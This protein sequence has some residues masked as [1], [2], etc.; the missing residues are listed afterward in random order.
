MSRMMRNTIAFIIII[1]IFYFQDVTYAS[2]ME[3]Q[4]QHQLFADYS[5]H[6]RP[7]KNFSDVLM[8]G[9]SFSLV[10]L[11]DVDEKNQIVTL[12]A[13]IKHTWHDYQLQ[14]NPGDY[15][16]IEEVV[17]PEEWVWTPDLALANSA[18]DNIMFIS[19]SRS[20]S[21]SHN[22]STRAFSRMVL[23]IPCVMDIRLFPFDTQTCSAY[24]SFWQY[25]HNFVQAES[26]T[27][28]SII[29]GAIENSEWAVLNGTIDV[30]VMYTYFPVEAWSLVV[31]TLTFKRK[32][33]YYVMNIIIPATLMALLTLLVHII[34]CDCGE[35][36]SFSVSLLISMSVFNLMVGNLLPA[37]SESVPLLAQYLLFNTVFVSFSICMAAVVLRLHHRQKGSLDMSFRIRRIFIDILPPFLLIKKYKSPGINKYDTQ[38]LCSRSNV[39]SL[40]SSVNQVD[41][42]D[43]ND[44]VMEVLDEANECRNGKNENFNYSSHLLKTNALHEMLQDM[45]HL[46][47]EAKHQEVDQSMLE[48]WKYV[49]MVIDRL[50]LW[51]SVIV[52]TVGTI[53]MFSQVYAD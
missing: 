7:V 41:I 23:A 22:G 4:L 18:T 5:A 19:S 30:I 15:D 17:I 52:F 37:T 50:C 6:V 2:S 53:A 9:F 34:P 16:G 10:A 33:S 1:T 35:K 44:A 24:F 27:D 26:L 47:R 43:G 28:Q 29:N 11:M 38:L 49:A 36:M 21:V 40:S 51:I 8:I 25:T 42:S 48:D 13:L 46:R 39:T 32:P 12:R 3:K 31:M 20:V 45:K 14:W